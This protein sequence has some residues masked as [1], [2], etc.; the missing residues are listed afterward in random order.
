MMT[1]LESWTI[2]TFFECIFN[3]IE[4]TWLYLFYKNFFQNNKKL[5]PMLGAFV[6]FF[7]ICLLN[8]IQAINGTAMTFLSLCGTLLYSLYCFSDYF[9]RKLFAGI[10]PLVV[11][12]ISD[13]ATFSISVV[14]HVFRPESAWVQSFERFLMTFIFCIISSFLY[15]VIIFACRKNR[16]FQNYPNTA[17]IF[18]LFLLGA[19]ILA[20]NYLINIVSVLMMSNS[21]SMDIYSYIIFIGYVFLALFVS[22]ILFLMKWTKSSYQKQELQLQM[23]YMELKDEYYESLRLA[24]EQFQFFRHDFSKHM[25]LLDILLEKGKYQKASAYLKELNDSY[26]RELKIIHYTDDEILNYIISNK[27]QTAKEKHIDVRVSVTKADISVLSSQELCCVLDNLFDNAIHANMKVEVEEERFI[28]LFLF[29]KESSISIIMKNRYDGS[30][31]PFESESSM[32]KGVQEMH[33]YGLRI[34][35]QFVTQAHGDIST[36]FDINNH[37]FIMELTIPYNWGGGIFD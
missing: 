23:Q 20:V 5:R 24:I 11:T 6:F 18:M 30:L 12:I 26:H 2:W 4:V 7:Y 29:E 16:Q 31:A 36:K 21:G 27:R 10:L 25:N 35:E 13:F 19:G 8:N 14:L 33:G 1:V 34:I 3:G 32:K 22:V 28:E 37:I 15:M 9:S 17:L